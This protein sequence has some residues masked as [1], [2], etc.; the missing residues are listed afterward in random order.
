MFGN[1]PFGSLAVDQSDSSAGAGPSTK[2]IEGEETDVEWL[3]LVKTNHDVDVRVSEKVELEGLPNECN[4]LAVSNRWGL[5]IVGS[6][7]DI[8]IHRLA[9]FHNLLEEAAKD[10]S[11]VSTPIQTIPLPSR[12]VWIRLAMNEERLVVATGNGAGVCIFKLRDIVGGNTSPYHTFSSSIPSHLLDVLPNPA[13]SS[14]DHLARYVTLL[15][16]EGLVITD[17]EGGKLSEPLSGPFTCASWS[18]KGKQIAVGTPAGTIVQ[19][20]PEGVAKSEIPSPPELGSYYPTFIQWLENDLFFVS[21]AQTGSQ[22]DDP[23]ETYIIHRQKTAFT[24]SKFYDPLNTMGLPDRSGTYRHFAELRSWGEKTKHLAFVLSGMASEIGILHGNAT[25]DK[26]A[27]KWEVL[28]PEETARGI[29][30]AAKPGVR[31]DTSALG[32]ALDL[33]STKVIRQGIVGGVEQPDLPPAPR[34]LAYSQEGVIISFDVHYPEAGSY[35][36]MMTPLDLAGAATQPA[37]EAMEVGTGA[38][39]PVITSTP[40][41]S[42]F[43]SAPNAI[44]STAFGSTAFGKTTPAKPTSAF[45]S[46]GFGQTSAP[47]FGSTSK[48][49]GFGASAFGQH[50]TPAATTPSSRSAAFSGFGQSSAPAGFGQS[51]FGQSAKPAAFGSSSSPASAFG[52]TAP[53]ATPSA[54]GS[55]AI[56]GSSFGQSAFGQS[57]KPASSSPAPFGQASKAAAATQSAFGAQSSPSAFGSTATSAFGSSSTPNTSLGFGAFSANK[58]TPGSTAFGFGT[59]AFGQ[60]AK[61]DVFKATGSTSAFGSSGSAFGSSSAFG[62]GSAFGASAFP[63]K[64]SPAA[65]TDAPKPVFAG[66]GSQTALQV[67]PASQTRSAASIPPPMSPEDDFGLAGFASALVTSTKPAAVPG[68]EQSPP[69]SPVTGTS[70]R[71]AGLTDDTPPNSPPLPPAVATKPAVPTKPAASSFIKPAT[72]FGD[73]VTRGNFGQTSSTKSNTTAFGSGSTP[74]AL[75]VNPTIATSSPSAFGSTAFGKPSAIGGA[76]S[77]SGFGTSTFGQPTKPVGFGISSAPA[78]AGKPLGAIAGG[79]SAFGAKTEGEKKPAGFGAFATASVGKSVFGDNRADT[80]NL[81]SKT[82][83][84]FAASAHTS[85]AASS[86]PAFGFSKPTSDSFASITPP[87]LPSSSPVSE[88]ALKGYDVPIAFENEPTDTTTPVQTPSKQPQAA[89]STTSI[90]AFSK[91]ASS[92]IEAN[93]SAKAAGSTPQQTT[94]PPEEHNRN[95]Q[96]GESVVEEAG[97]EGNGRPDAK[98]EVDNNYVTDGEE[99][100]RETAEDYREDKY[101]DGGEEEEVFDDEEGDG[102]K[103]EEEEHDEEEEYDEEEEEEYEAEEE[104]EYGEEEEYDEEQ[105]EDDNH[106]EDETDGRRR[107]STSFPPDMSPITEETR[108]DEPEDEDEE[109][110]HREDH[111]DVA[112]SPA[113]KVFEKSKIR[114]PPVWFTKPPKVDEV[115]LDPPSPTPASSGSS[116]FSRL[117]PQPAASESIMFGDTPVA[118]QAGPKLP[119]S[120]SFKHAARTSSPLSGP[121][122]TVDEST[123]ADQSPAMPA[124]QGGAFD[125][126]GTAKTA[127]PFNT[128]VESPKNLVAPSAGAFGA[129]ETKAASPPNSAPSSA[130]TGGSY[131]TSPEASTSI[132]AAARTVP[133]II[134]ESQK[135]SVGLGLGRPGVTPAVASPAKLDNQS[136]TSFSFAG[137]GGPKQVISSPLTQGYEVVSTKMPIIEP[138]KKEEARPATSPSTF[139]VPS[140]FAVPIQPQRPSNGEK[141]MAAVMERIINSL[142]DDIKRIKDVLA[143]NA[144]YHKAFSAS[145]MPHVNASN[146]A[147][148]NALPFSSIGDL[149]SIVEGLSNELAELR[150]KDSGAELKLAELQ[151]KMLKTDVKVGQADKF[152]KARRDPSFARVMQIKDLSPEQ[153]AIQV[154]IRKAVQ[155][156]ESRLEELDESVAGLKRRA[157]RREQGR[158]GSSQPALERVQRSVRN[159]DAAIRDRQQTIDELARRIGSIRLSNSPSRAS[160]AGSPA[161]STIASHHQTLTT[162]RTIDFEPSKDVKVEVEAALDG[163]SKLKRPLGGLKVA[164]FTKLTTCSPRSGLLAHASISKGPLMIDALPSPGQLPPDIVSKPIPTPAS[165]QDKAPPSTAAQVETYQAQTQPEPP[166]FGAIKFS[167]E[168]GDISSLAGSR[169]GSRGSAGAISSHRTHSA[170]AKFVPQAGTIKGAAGGEGGLFSLPSTNKDASGSGGTNGSKQAPSGFFSFSGFGKN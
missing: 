13:P 131:I 43:S 100:R 136:T 46:P 119:S 59:S 81:P 116:L 135:P 16:S 25:P 45:G 102:E 83:N 41:P 141:T 113:A 151:S 48:P 5:L 170:A 55:A 164:T 165:R 158:E 56:S 140:R 123:T 160:R 167:L 44:G 74:A 145:D 117:G 2:V 144:Q 111:S 120:F 29:L 133:P 107:R 57:T 128:S 124:T 64:A 114:S 91:P 168:A 152:L 14:S 3:K 1:N 77:A 88:E 137:I 17:I 166:S 127:T 69:S 139:T 130:F 146:L 132:P 24:Y 67:K 71:P 90:Q 6:N 60:P 33:T 28:I 42:A 129:F 150:A 138:P 80:D 39:T 161:V 78:A 8:R 7:N 95:D 98:A 93:T 58:S 115:E 11:P 96:A 52:Q 142:Q 87:S 154:Q 72:A 122:Q 125:F 153:A 89:K 134:S 68:L 18:A 97:S 22:P 79:F 103:E 23:I 163:I 157:E 10:A 126:F 40:A 37:E 92:Y 32:L 9:D 21:Y 51:A 110:E 147:T 101:S 105:V 31:D 112:T 82:T 159:I 86:T 30:P 169:S 20:T 73:A 61:D 155:V 4:L 121:P 76:G 99:Y 34:L 70:T 162:W 66:F 50:T 26:E 106:V 54:F 15:A 27:P 118:D 85:P 38:N 36:G 65:L 49:S 12:P 84:I 109:E 94:S 75:S 62:T 47:V 148:H 35:P 156:A 149:T 104:E 63:Q 108:E 19:Y 53:A 143:A